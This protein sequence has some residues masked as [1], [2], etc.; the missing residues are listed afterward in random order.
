MFLLDHL[1]DILF[2]TVAVIFAVGVS[3]FVLSRQLNR[4]NNI[5]DSFDSFSDH[6]SGLT[7][8]FYLPNL[9]LEAGKRFVREHGE[10]PF[11]DKAAKVPEML[12]INDD[13]YGELEEVDIPLFKPLE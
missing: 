7:N 12:K 1:Q 8:E 6:S 4:S 11:G 9:S 3:L 2:V 5:G 13:I 10:D